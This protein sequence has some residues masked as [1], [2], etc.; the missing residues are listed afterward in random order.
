M[1]VA[2]CEERDE[3]DPLGAV[4]PAT[5]PPPS[6]AKADPL[7]ATRIVKLENT[8]LDARPRKSRPLSLACGVS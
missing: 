5:V 4:P 1:G 8:T 2:E 7:I 3:D 6:L